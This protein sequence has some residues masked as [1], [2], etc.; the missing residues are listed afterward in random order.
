MNNPMMDMQTDILQWA[1]NRG[2]TSVGSLG[3]PREAPYAGYDFTPQG[4]KFFFVKFGK[5]SLFEATVRIFH[6]SVIQI[7]SW[8]PGESSRL[9]TWQFAPPRKSRSTMKDAKKIKG[10]GSRNQRKPIL[11][12]DLRSSLEKLEP[13]Y[14]GVS[15]GILAE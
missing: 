13:H 1:T 12:E 10:L 4:E 14:I 8:A 6:P 15:L 3:G 2:Y 7:R 5:P 9:N 11:W